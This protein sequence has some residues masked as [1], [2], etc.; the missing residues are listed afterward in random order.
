MLIVEIFPI[1]PTI[2]ISGVN[3]CLLNECVER[4]LDRQPH[5]EYRQAH[6]GHIPRT[7]SVRSD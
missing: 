2:R 4:T 1:T 5:R 7:H 6:R 3:A